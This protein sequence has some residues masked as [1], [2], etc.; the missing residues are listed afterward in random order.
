MRAGRLD[1][2][3]SIQRS[4]PTQ[5]VSGEPQPSWARI[6]PVRWASVEAVAGDERF[7]S[8]Q[9][10]AR[11]Q[12]EFNVRWSPDIAD[13]SPGDRIVYPVT[14]DPEPSEI[15]DIMAVH[16]IGRREGLRIITARRAETT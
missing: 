10:I 11:Q 5:D 2:R 15:Y 16:E 6:G 3:V 7:I 4:T 14:N 12:N 8:E 9:F 1:R 13:L